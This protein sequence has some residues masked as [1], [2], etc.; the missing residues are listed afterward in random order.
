MYFVIWCESEWRISRLISRNR[1]ATRKSFAQRKPLKNHVDTH[2][3]SSFA[4]KI[5]VWGWALRKRE[6][7]V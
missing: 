7:G 6:I 2:A 5:L 3:F 1:P 4:C